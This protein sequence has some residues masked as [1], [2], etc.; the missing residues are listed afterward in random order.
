MEDKKETKT[1]RENDFQRNPPKIEKGKKD[2]NV[3]R[4]K[5]GKKKL[6]DIFKHVEIDLNDDDNDVVSDLKTKLA[7]FMHAYT[8]MRTQVFNYIIFLRMRLSQ[9]IHILTHASV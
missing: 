2:R 7:I 1:T 8:S 3:S 9:R 5:R 6:E 4:K